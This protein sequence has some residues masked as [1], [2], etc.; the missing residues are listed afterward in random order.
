MMRNLS[1]EEVQVVSGGMSP[2]QVI[3]RTLPQAIQDFQ[4]SGGG[5]GSGRDDS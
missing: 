1:V 2:L 3:P 4:A 5:A